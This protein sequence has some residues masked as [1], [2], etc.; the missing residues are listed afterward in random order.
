MRYGKVS[1]TIR[2]AGTGGAVTAFIMMADGGDEID[3]EIIGG[4]SRHV[5]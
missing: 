4:D 3:F 2:S 1:A 5:Q